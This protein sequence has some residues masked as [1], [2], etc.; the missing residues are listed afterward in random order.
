[1][2]LA[3]L[4][5]LYLICCLLTGY[6]GKY[7]RMGVMGTFLLSIVVTPLLMLLILVITGPSEGIEWRPKPER[8]RLSPPV[9][10]KE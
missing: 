3:S 8:P 2:A 4:I 7:R 9:G 5:V 1:M 10:T 6:L